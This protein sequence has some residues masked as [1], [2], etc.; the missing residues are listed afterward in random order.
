MSLDRLAKIGRSL[1]LPDT[2]RLDTKRGWEGLV[3]HFLLHAAS[4][5]ALDRIKDTKPQMARVADRMQN[6][7]GP[8]SMVIGSLFE[9]PRHR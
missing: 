9:S 8:I 7:S 3:S 5:I 2:S 6:K 4:T 1:A